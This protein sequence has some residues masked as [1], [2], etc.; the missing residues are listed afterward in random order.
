MSTVHD[1]ETIA[2]AEGFKKYLPFH[3]DNTAL[4]LSRKRTETCAL[5]RIC[6]DSLTHSATVYWQSTQ[7]D[8][9]SKTFRNCESLEIFLKGEGSSATQNYRR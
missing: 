9:A 7:D 8:I 2:S 1:F 5:M 6:I 4:W 3:T